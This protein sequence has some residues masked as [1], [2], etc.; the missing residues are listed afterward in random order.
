MTPNQSTE[1]ELARLGRA[2][3][4]PTRVR[5]ISQLLE[6]GET[7]PRALSVALDE[8]L[9]NVSYHMRYLADLGMVRLEST[10]PRR[11]ALEHF[12]VLDADIAELTRRQQAVLGGSGNGKTPPTAA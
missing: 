2:L 11:G 10:A 6:G 8:P 12:Y 4:H 7:S 3:A 1:Q 5:M 9:G